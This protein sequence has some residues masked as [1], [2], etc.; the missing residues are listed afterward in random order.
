MWPLVRTTSNHLIPNSRFGACDGI[1]DFG[2]DTLIRRPH[3]F[4]DLVDMIFHWAFV[5]MLSLRTLLPPDIAGAFFFGSSATIA[6]VVIRR[7][8]TEAAF[9]R[10]SSLGWV[11][12]SHT[13]PSSA[14]C[15]AR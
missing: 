2:F 14:R 9:L 5:P 4:Q 1:L 10:G 3:E 7:P 6:S 12:V 15:Y 13:K 11:K 8:A